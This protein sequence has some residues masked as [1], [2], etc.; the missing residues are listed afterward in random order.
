VSVRRWAAFIVAMAFVAALAGT[1]VGRTLL[2]APTSPSAQLHDFIHNKLG[3]DAR[4]HAQV[5]ALEAKFDGRRRALESELRLDNARL[6][7]AIAQEHGY[8]PGVRN[9]VDRSHLAMGEL[10]KE[11]LAH[12]FAMRQVL[13]PDQA[14]RYDQA[15]VRTLT[16]ESQ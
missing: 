6:A 5:Y 9:A 3:L 1:L 10:Q 14:A 12:V 7:V 2:P 11:T 4:Q 8:G 16:S 13:R 15:V